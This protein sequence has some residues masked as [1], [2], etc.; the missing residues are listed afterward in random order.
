M[1]TN[2]TSSPPGPALDQPDAGV[3]ISAG[4]PLGVGLLALLLG[5]G[6]ASRSD[7]IVDP[8]ALVAAGLLGAGAAFVALTLVEAATAWRARRLGLQSGPVVVSAWGPSLPAAEAPRDAAQAYAL[9]RIK[10]LAGLGV[11][12]ALLLGA[13][14]AFGAGWAPLAATVFGA[15]LL[16]GALTVLDL[17]PAPGRSG[18]LL[19]LARAW[20][21][22]E[23]AA[24]EGT[25][26]RVGI[27]AGWVLVAAGLVAVLLVGVAGVWLAFVGWLTLLHSRLE[28]ARVKLHSATAAVPVGRV[29][30]EH[31][32]E[33]QG[34]ST[35]DAVLAEHARSPHRLLAMRRFDGHLGV[36]LVDELLTVPGDDRT[37]RRVQD[38]ARPAVLLTPQDP[39]E[40][41]IDPTSAA[42]FGVVT[43]DRSG[44][45]P[46]LGVVGPAEIARAGHLAP[47]G[48]PSG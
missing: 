33:V 10:P 46:V 16:T 44:E 48:A 19:V 5:L 1:T 13:A 9:G 20:R 6:P 42:P 32:P 29:M 45:G 43:A 21:R 28:Q 4:A 41:L 8:A 11:V 12:L 17:L 23:R 7:S 2:R 40:R 27:R 14:A 37:T 39:V 30:I 24:A 18:G 26:A 25:V 22:G 15:A 38:L 36:V 3:R 34:W 31:P 35:V 47:A